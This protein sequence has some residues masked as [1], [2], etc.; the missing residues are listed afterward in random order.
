[1]SLE[2]ICADLRASSI[3]KHEERAAREAYAMSPRIR[4]LIADNARRD[5]A[6]GMG[7][8]EQ[9]VAESVEARTY[10]RIAAEALYMVRLFRADPRMSRKGWEWW[11]ARAQFCRQQAEALS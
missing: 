6:S 9:L 4:R 7:G 3:R 10:K 5:F 8:L 1:M 11:F 2:R